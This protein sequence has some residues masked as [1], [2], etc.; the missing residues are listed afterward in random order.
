M[1]YRNIDQRISNFG[2]RLQYNKLY[3][4]EY[5]PAR[6]KYNQF[7]FL[8]TLGAWAAYNAGSLWGFT[9]ER[10]KDLGARR[11]YTMPRRF[12]N[13]VTNGLDKSALSSHISK[14]EFTL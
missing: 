8:A 13:P 3:K 12:T 2:F 5:L 7:F 10:E 9:D 11:Y 14:Q 1:E 6:V 4:A